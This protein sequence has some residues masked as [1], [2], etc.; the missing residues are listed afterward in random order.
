MKG[1]K[2]FFLSALLL[3]FNTAPAFAADG[4]EAIEEIVVT[5]SYLKR[6]AQDSPSPLSVITSADIEDI[7]AQDMSEIVATLPWQSGSQTQATTF[8]GE[9]AD[10]QNSINLRNMGH[11]ATLPLV[12]GKRQVASWYNARANA[13]VNVNNLVPNIALER[14]EIV[15]DGASALYGSDAMAGVVNFITKKDFEGFDV[16]YEFST[17]DETTEGDTNNFQAIWGIQGDRGGV[18]VSAGSLNRDE[19]TIGD[20]YDRFG[21]SSASSTGQPG[22]FQPVAG[23]DIVW[24][25][26][27]VDPGAS[28]TVLDAAG[29]QRPPRR[30]DGSSFGQAD[31][32]CEVAAAVEEGGPLGLVGPDICA[33]DFGS[34]F[35]LQAEE[36]L[37][38]F[39]VT[40][41]YDVSDNFEAYFEFAASDSE[42]DRQNSLNPNALN[43]TIDGQIAAAGQPAQHFGNIEDAFRRGIEPISVLNRTRLV[44]GTADSNAAPRPISTFTDISRADQRMIV[45]GVWDL[46]FGDRSW[47][48]DLSYTAT[49]H[50]SSVSQVQDTLSTE[51][52]L[53]ING[54]GGPGCDPINGTPGEG[55]LAYAASGGDF[56]AG[57]CYFFNPFGNANFARDG[58]QQT[59]LTLVNPVELYEWLLG[60]VTNDI[61]YRERVLEGVLAGEIFDTDS[62][63]IGLAVG[64][65]RRRTHA[66]VIYDAAPHTHNL[67]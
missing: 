46:E 30:A 2:F 54:L 17:D 58:S 12:N 26:N 51:M 62:G 19:I 55:N 10:G 63:P 21:G 20:R 23:Q 67:H 42:F 48:L 39:H 53:A 38:K 14:I 9:G 35:A 41:H 40:G 18:V 64:L 4:D 3:C 27:G 45:G 25:A 49:E 22:R 1:I 43:L 16:S 52:N 60:R 61:E 7:G 57:N 47:T 59:D 13:S 31:V 29:N 37:R 11:G 32:D 50:D 15:K 44:G 36:S 6:S 8:G 65:Q 56:L 66:T 5:G 33:Y 28:I 34:F 24:A